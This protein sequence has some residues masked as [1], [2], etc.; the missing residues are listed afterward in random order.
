VK[1]RFVPAGTGDVTRLRQIAER[2]ASERVDAVIVRSSDLGDPIVLAA[3][4]VDTLPRGL[5]GA[6]LCLE[7]D[8]RHPSVL[9]RDMTALD[10][11][12]AG[13]AVLCLMP[14][15]DDGTVEAIAILR[16][17]WRD[18]AAESTGPRYPVP[19]AVN[20]PL[21]PGRDSPLLALDLTDSED[22]T[23][24][25]AVSGPWASLVDLLV[26][27]TGDPADGQCRLERTRPA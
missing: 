10:H 22:H 21:P 8:G 5:L 13:R 7:A 17:M 16:A 24:D 14:P 26:F 25:A 15:F 4:L 2:A 11:V 19:G 1:G 27:G 3:G 6:S 9:A 12:C 23:D 20:R 18:G